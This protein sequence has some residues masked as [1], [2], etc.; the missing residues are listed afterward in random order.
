MTQLVEALPYSRKVVDS[1]PEGIIGIF[2]CLNPSSLIMDLV[3]TQPITEMST[4]G[5]EGQRG[6]VRRADNLATFMYRLSK[7]LEFLTSWNPQ[8]LSRPVQRLL[9]LVPS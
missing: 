7:N 4:P 1:I 6:P 8:G 3:S 9:Y 2:Y 5:G